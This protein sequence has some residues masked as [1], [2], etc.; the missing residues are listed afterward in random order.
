[1]I[2]NNCNIIN[3]NFRCCMICLL[4]FFVAY[5]VD[6]KFAMGY[7]RLKGK[8]CLFP[9][10]L[11]CTGMPIKVTRWPCVLYN[12][13]KMLTC[14]CEMYILYLKQVFLPWVEIV[15]NCSVPVNFF[16]Q[17]VMQFFRGVAQSIVL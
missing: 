16:W 4:I 8:R 15:M 12:Y 6:S 10:G 13:S 5:F 17:R 9:F 2:N 7:H 11:H 1:M 3:K 14:K